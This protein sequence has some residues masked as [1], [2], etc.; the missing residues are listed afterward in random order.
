M[1]DF[2]PW[3]ADLDA[4]V[5]AQNTPGRAA[6]DPHGP[7]HQYF[8]AK[9]IEAER[10]AVEAGDGFAILACV[11][12]CLTNGLVAPAWLSYAFNKKYDAVKNYRASS[13]DSP[14]SFG[15]PYKKGAHLAARRK[16]WVKSLAVYLEICEIRKRAPDTP[17]D[18]RLFEDVG[19]P[20]GLGGTLT[21]EYYYRHARARLTGKT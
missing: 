20:M 18:K 1:T 2:D 21:E 14:L 5:A 6:V 15:R 10:P 8:A 16:K 12:D 7:V 3:T 9:H 4:A 19:R 11:R 17:I 13:W